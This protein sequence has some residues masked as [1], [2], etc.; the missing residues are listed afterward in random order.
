MGDLP[1]IASKGNNTATATGKITVLYG[2]L[3]PFGSPKRTPPIKE[4][5]LVWGS[6]PGKKYCRSSRDPDTTKNWCRRTRIRGWSVLP[7]MDMVSH[8]EETMT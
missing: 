8:L 4:P 7:S 1:L 6:Q 3:I 2:C 5:W